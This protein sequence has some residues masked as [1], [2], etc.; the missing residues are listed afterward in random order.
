M[1]TTLYP[2]PCCGYLV[3][4]EGPG[5]DVHCPICFWQEDLAQLRFATFSYGPNK[6]SLVEAQLNTVK[7]GMI[8]PGYQR[9][10][11]CPTSFERDEG[12][13]LIDLKIDNIELSI[14]GDQGRTYPQDMTTLYYWRDTYWR[15]QPQSLKQDELL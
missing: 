9:R 11:P 8:V 14:V 7:Y 6:L 1:N 2:C 15:R 13:R 3:F 5:S 12:W 4:K 10:V